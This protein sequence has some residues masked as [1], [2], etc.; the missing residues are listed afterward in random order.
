MKYKLILLTNVDNPKFGRKIPF[1]FEVLF[2]CGRTVPYLI[3]SVL[4][5]LMFY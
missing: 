3:Q 5:L 1:T 2:Y 4:L